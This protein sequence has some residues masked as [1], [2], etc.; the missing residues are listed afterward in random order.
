MS[1]GFQGTVRPRVSFSAGNI[2]SHEEFTKQNDSVYSG[3]KQKPQKCKGGGTKGSMSRIFHL[4][5][6]SGRERWARFTAQA[7]MAMTKT[8]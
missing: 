8:S 1:E 2:M 5:R 3:M 6:K 4:K 7:L